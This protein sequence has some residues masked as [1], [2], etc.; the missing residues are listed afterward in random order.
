MQRCLRFGVAWITFQHGQSSLESNPGRD[1]FVESQVEQSQET[2]HSCTSG[3]L[4]CAVMALTMASTPCFAAKEKKNSSLFTRHE[5]KHFV[6]CPPGE[7]EAGHYVV[8]VCMY[9]CMYVE[10]LDCVSCQN[11]NSS[12][13]I[14]SFSFEAIFRLETMTTVNF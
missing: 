13:F 10:I 6:L 9:V 7:E 11:A 3:I 2:T 12:S 1:G 14:F 4:L 5:V 8:Y